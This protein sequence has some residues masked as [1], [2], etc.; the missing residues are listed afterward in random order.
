MAKIIPV[1]KSEDETDANNYRPTSLLSNYID[2][3]DLLYS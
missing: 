2:K 3:H 1:Y